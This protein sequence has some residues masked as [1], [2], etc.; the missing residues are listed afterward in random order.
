MKNGC[1]ENKYYGGARTPH[2]IKFGK[3][4][5]KIFVIEDND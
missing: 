3:N 1:F 2:S 4:I 5:P